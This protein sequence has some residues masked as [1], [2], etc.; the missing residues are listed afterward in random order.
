MREIVFGHGKVL[1]ASVVDQFGRVGVLLRPV[2][3]ARKVDQPETDWKEGEPYEAEE[4]DVMI[5]FDNLAGVRVLQDRVNI[6]C[7]QLNRFKVTDVGA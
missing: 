4:N 5:W 6:A 7:L 1:A 2:E 3:A